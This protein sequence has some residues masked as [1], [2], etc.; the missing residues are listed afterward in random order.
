[1]TINNLSDLN[2]KPLDMEKLS[3]YNGGSWFSD[4]VECHALIVGFGVGL[5]CKPIY[6]AYLAG[7]DAGIKA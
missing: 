5:I 7:Y 4:I 2:V 3:D 6:G 1:M